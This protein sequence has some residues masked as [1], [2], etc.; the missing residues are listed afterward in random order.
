MLCMLLIRVEASPA[1]QYC[2]VLV[3]D[4][5]LYSYITYH[6]TTVFSRFF[7]TCC[8]PLPL[9]LLSTLRQQVTSVREVQVITAA[10]AAS[11]LDGYFF[12]GFE[13]HWSEKIA[14]DATADE[15]ASALAG[16][17]A[18]GEVEVKIK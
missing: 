3:P 12:V 11:D 18:A 2:F 16:I 7:P 10:A 8:L 14:H 5:G 13:G 17:P 1:L 15:M 4:L 9:Y 6:K